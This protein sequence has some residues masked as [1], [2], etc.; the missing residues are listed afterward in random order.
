MRAKL[1]RLPPVCLRM[2]FSRQRPRIAA[3]GRV[4][5]RLNPSQ[6]NLLL[7]H[8][9]LPAPLA[10]ALK[11]AAVRDGKLNVRVT[12]PELDRLIVAVAAIR[13]LEPRERRTLDAWLDYLES[14]DDRFEDHAAD[15]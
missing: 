9:D 7:D 13:P 8:R 6:R 14:L 12:R 10:F 15:E 11:H 1:S 5:V 4:S 3:T 2:A